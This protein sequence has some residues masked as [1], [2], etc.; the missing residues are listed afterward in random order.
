M[1]VQSSWSARFA[2]LALVTLIAAVAACVPSQDELSGGASAMSARSGPLP[3]TK[4]ALVN[5]DVSPFPFSGMIPEKDKPF[6]D[7]S[8]S[9][10]HGHTTPSGTI[11]WEDQAY[12]DRHV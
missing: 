10:R 9:D 8:I 2:K 6:L 4:T 5:F 11:V 3:S 1:G 7:V 12:H